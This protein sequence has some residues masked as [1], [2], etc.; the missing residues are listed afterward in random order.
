MSLLDLG[1]LLIRV[2]TRRPLALMPCH[3]TPL[4]HQHTAGVKRPVAQLGVLSPPLGERLVAAAEVVVENLRDAEVAAGD[5]AE[6]VGVGR[7]EVLR[8][9]HVELDPLWRRHVAARHHVA[10]AVGYP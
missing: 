1:T 2:G 4:R 8:T 9:A 5:D 10:D 7:R 3:G 6:Q